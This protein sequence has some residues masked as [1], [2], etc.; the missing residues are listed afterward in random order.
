MKN[1]GFTLIEALA[2]AFV[3]TLG[4]VEVLVIINQTTAFT[5][6]TSSRLTAAYL[7]QEGIEIVKNIRDTNFLK[8]HKGIEGVNWDD[9]LIGCTA[10]CEADYNDPALSSAD[11]YL[12]ID[13]GFYNYD[14]GA[15]TRFKR[16]ITV[17]P[18][19]DTLEILVEVSWQE[20]NREHK[21]A[22]QENIYKWW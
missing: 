17:T 9:G 2:A 11:R 3:I 14:S 12:K 7:A 6:V 22:A 19:T 1:K 16:K 18:D 20:R 15:N 13:G 4:V 21:V 5:Q 10:G 8:I